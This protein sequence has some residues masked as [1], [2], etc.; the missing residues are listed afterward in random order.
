MPSRNPENL[1]SLLIT[2]DLSQAPVI[3]EKPKR[4]LKMSKLPDGRTKVEINFSSLSLIN[5]CLRKAQYSLIGGYKSNIEAEATL[6]GKGIHKGLEHWY[7]LPPHLKIPND[8]EEGLMDTLLAGP[9]KYTEPPVY[10]TALDSVNEFVKVV[11]PLRWMGDS[12][13]RSVN[14]GIKILK[15][16]F[17]HY[18]GD[19][20]E[21]LKDESGKPYIERELEMVLFEDDHKVI[22]LFGTL[23]V[24]FRNLITGEIMPGDHKTTAALGSSFYNRIKP[25]H[26]YTA[27][28]M[29]A[30]ECLGLDVSQFMVNG[31]QVAKT[32][33]EFA[34]QITE[35][36]E[37]DFVEF[38]MAVI[39]AVER[40]LRAVETGAFPM[41]S[42][43]S[44]TNYGSCQYL[45]VC[46]SPSKLR[47]TVLR[48]KYA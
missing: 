48:S 42:P 30:R 7:Q 27:Y 28:I 29:L 6:F 41:N 36:G 12:D 5:D 40:L 11:Q 14:N 24:I 33:S 32:K 34:R 43:G 10:E 20:L 37:E 4:M 39:E 17:R 13:K 23:D 3:L 18:Q 35:R 19:G 8:A 15:A 16:Y 1:E 45:D 38:R 26:Q 47:E 44:C 46:S 22:V 31:I 9:L 25:N 2:P 21:V